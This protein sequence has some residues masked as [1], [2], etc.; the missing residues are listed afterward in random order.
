VTDEGLDKGFK[1]SQPCSYTR[2]STR[3]RNGAGSEEAGRVAAGS[4][5]GPPEP[6]A[7]RRGWRPAADG[8]AEKPQVPAL[9][10]CLDN[11][12]LADR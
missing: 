8:G 12:H 2:L 6:R 11:C 7:A 3:T 5:E 1:R 9:G 4:G 10:T